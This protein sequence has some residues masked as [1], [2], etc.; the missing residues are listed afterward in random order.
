MIIGSHCGLSAPLFMEGSVKEALSYNANAL[1]IYTGAPQNTIRKSVSSLRVNEALKLMEENGFKKEHFIIHAPYIIN[2]ASPD[3]EKRQFSID[4][5]SEEVRRV[6][7]MGAHI[8]VLHPGNHMGENL[9]EAINRISDSLNQ[10]I[11]NTV[12]CKTIIA[13][14]T[15]AGKGTECGKT[16]EEIKKIIDGVEKKDRIGV[17]LD[18]CHVNDAGYD[19]VN[20][21]ESVIEE[22]NNIIGLDKIKVIH[23]NDSKNPL[24]SHKD[25]HENIGKGYL[26]YDTIKHVCEDKRFENIAKILETPYV[27]GN[28]PYKEEI[29]LLRK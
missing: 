1:M 23:I 11:A 24:G 20:N 5:L 8:M 19:L 25:R 28:A 6:E 22:F 2:P 12:N 26:G 17:C 13:L 10:I 9:E 27:E 16:F 18:T 4:F 15:M 3:S 21:Y 7:Q 29:A 14:E